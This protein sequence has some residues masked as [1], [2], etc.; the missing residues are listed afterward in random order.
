MS[1]HSVPNP[2]IR[3]TVLVTPAQKEA[4]AKDSAETGKAMA[5]IVRDMF[6][7]KYGD[8]KTVAG[9]QIRAELTRPED[10]SEAQP[11]RARLREWVTR[12][13]RRS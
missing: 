4:L 13:R 7:A 3:L 12:S 11:A 2:L 6:D 8:P 1:A 10:T 5:Q 9:W